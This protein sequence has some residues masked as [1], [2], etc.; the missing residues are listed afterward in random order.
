[1]ET[2]TIGMTLV[3]AVATICAT[4]WLLKCGIKWNENKLKN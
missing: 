2:T 4:I 3:G 1:M